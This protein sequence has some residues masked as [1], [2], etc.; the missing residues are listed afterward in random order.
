MIVCIDRI[1]HVGKTILLYVFAAI[2]IFLI[3]YL[4]LLNGSLSGNM[5]RCL[6]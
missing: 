4:Y 3:L 5:L 1:G 2:S 6:I